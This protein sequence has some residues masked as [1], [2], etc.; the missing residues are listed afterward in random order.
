MCVHIASDSI[1]WARTPTILFVNE[2]QK[3][4]FIARN[5]GVLDK[6]SSFIRIDCVGEEKRFDSGAWMVEKSRN[7]M[8]AQATYNQGLRQPKLV[9]VPR[10]AEWGFVSKEV[11]HKILV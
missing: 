8:V 10:N 9:H 6:S 1:Q 5:F 2:H 7:S 3:S 11:L 4:I